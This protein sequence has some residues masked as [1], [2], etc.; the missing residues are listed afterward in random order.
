MSRKYIF[1]KRDNAKKGIMSTVL[2]IISIITLVLIIYFSF[3]R[4]GQIP[5]RYATTMLITSIFSLSGI[6]LGTI[7][8]FEKEKFHLFPGVGVF[9]NTV[10][11]GLIWFIVSTG[12]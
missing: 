5:E 10:A 6:V 11:L 1:T 4:D 7:G 9:L 3:L 2:G 8:L 12:L